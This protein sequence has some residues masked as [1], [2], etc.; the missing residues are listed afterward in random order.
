MD[1]T[2]SQPA[3]PVS[4]KRVGAAI[5]MGTALEYFDFF[6]YSAMAA[7]VIGPTFFPSSNSVASTIASLATFGVGYLARPFAGLIFG[8]I[9][10]KFGRKT[11]LSWSLI[12]MGVSS[13]LMGLIPSYATIGIAAPILL[14]LLRIVQ[15]V[16][17]GAE[18]SSAIA[19]SYEFAAPNKRG[20]LGSLPTLGVN[21]GVFA[22]SLVVA[23]LA[24][25]GNDFFY[26]WGWRI[27]F[28]LSFALAGVG[29][30]IR[31][32]LPESPEFLELRPDQ[33]R[34]T[35]FR[36]LAD[37]F[38][39]DWRGVL[40]VFI[41]YG[42]YALVATLWKT[43]ALSY[44]TEF[45]GIGPSV[46]TFGVTLASLFA[47]F[48]TPICGRLCDAVPIRGVLAVGGL[49]VI[50]YSV[51]FFW[52]L[53]TKTPIWIWVAL[54]LGTGF[55]APLLSVATS[56]FMARQFAT[57]T[58]VT[59]I[60]VG[61]ES[62]GALA[63]GLGPVIAIA[64]VGSSAS[65]STLGVSMIFALGGALF[66]IAAW[67]GRSVAPSVSLSDSETPARTGTGN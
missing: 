14:V 59:G 24:L 60:G 11:V 27:P 9:G 67:R 53:D 39:S 54:I 63:A 48:W 1:V 50:A 5:V 41:V 56:P 64:L 44:L 23:G 49:L 10:D 2:D 32:K 52:L 28:V 4:Q 42:G 18:F 33:T 51:P 57:N 31:L 16:G 45:Q 3:R 8:I 6:L 62:S 66:V 22:A 46:S 30:L 7:L 15:G 58:R 47:I 37:L 12:L 29:Y 34:R 20:R 38:R 65:S 40:I 17:A 43:F 61:K 26:S 36:V 19:V 55:L 21:L 25:I 35:W 13:G